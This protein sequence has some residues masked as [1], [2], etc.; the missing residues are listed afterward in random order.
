MRM[1]SISVGTTRLSG[2]AISPRVLSLAS[3]LR[4]AATGSAMA[5]VRPMHQPIPL[6]TLFRPRYAGCGGR[7]V[8]AGATSARFGVV[9]VKSGRGNSGRMISYDE[10]LAII[11]SAAKPLGTETVAL[12]QAAGRVLAVPVCAA[13]DSPRADVSAM[14]GYAVRGEDLNHFPVS[15]S[16]AGESFPG[17][18]WDGTVE[19][20]QCVRIFTGAPLSVGANRM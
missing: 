17:S 11:G 20:G 19:A 13:I 2:S 3:A 4:R 8:R 1:A 18:G 9:D 10:A 12:A 5:S 7:E 16:V 14:D 6:S 15:L